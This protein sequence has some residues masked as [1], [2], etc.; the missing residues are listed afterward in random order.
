M[1]THTQMCCTATRQHDLLFCNTT[2]TDECNQYV[3]YCRATLRCSTRLPRPLSNLF[4]PFFCGLPS[5]HLRVMG[6]VGGAGGAFKETPKETHNPLQ[7]P[8]CGAFKYQNGKKSNRKLLPADADG[9]QRT[10]GLVSRRSCD[11]RE[12]ARSTSCVYR[13]ASLDGEPPAVHQEDA[14]SL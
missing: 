10:S 11:V 3:S 13:H 4:R 7:N 12:R 14:N 2:P 6:K 9:I 1:D 8:E 5:S